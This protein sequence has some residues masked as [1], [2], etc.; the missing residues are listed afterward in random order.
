[1]LAVK[2]QPMFDILVN[3]PIYV[4]FGKLEIRSPIVAHVTFTGEGYE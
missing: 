1:M 4:H 3:L 2:R